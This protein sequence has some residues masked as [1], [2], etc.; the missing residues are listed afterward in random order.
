KLE[1]YATLDR[2]LEAYATY[3]HTA[4][5]R[6]PM[7]TQCQCGLDASQDGLLNLAFEFAGRVGNAPVQHN[8]VIINFG[9]P[10]HEIAVGSEAD[11]Y[12]V[13]PQVQFNL[14]YLMGKTLGQ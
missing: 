8:L 1:A 6:S 2:K 14:M 7:Y 5:S 13:I 4:L 12:P 11:V 9:L 10:L 3:L